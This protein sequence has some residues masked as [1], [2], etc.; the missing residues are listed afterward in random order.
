MHRITS[1]L[2]KLADQIINRCGK[3]MPS[4]H[5]FTKLWFLG[6]EEEENQY[7]TLKAIMRKRQHINLP[8]CLGQEKN[9]MLTSQQKDLSIEIL[10]KSLLNTAQEV[11]WRLHHWYLRSQ[12]YICQ[13]KN[14]KLSNSILHNGCFSLHCSLSN[15]YFTYRAKIT[16]KNTWTILDFQISV[17]A[18]AP[19]G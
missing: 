17:A 19:S 14:P 11:C 2:L 15:S 10:N 3:K 4:S 6:W 1:L 16:P 5:S 7:E 13:G 12:M 18:V 9:K 8:V